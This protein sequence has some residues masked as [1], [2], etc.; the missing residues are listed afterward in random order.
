MRK[1]QNIL[2]S[3]FIYQS[4]LFQIVI[5]YMPEIFN[6][7]N[8]DS[9]ADLENHIIASLGRDYAKNQEIGHKI[10]GTQKR[11]KQFGL[12]DTCTIWGVRV[13]SNYGSTDKDL[14]DKAGREGK[15][16]K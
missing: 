15:T 2:T 1:K 10:V 6:I 13:E 4:C 5:T 12:S 7:D 8:Y 3:I 16:W 9:R 14:K 11:L